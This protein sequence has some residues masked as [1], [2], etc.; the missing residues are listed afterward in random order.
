MRALNE[1]LIERKVEARYVS[2]LLLLWNPMTRQIVMANAGAIPPHDLPRGEILKAA[3]GGRAAG[4]ARCARVRRD[5]PFKRSRGILLVLYSDGITDH[6]NA[7]GTEYGR[8]RLSNAIRMH[9]KTSPAKMIA[10]IFDD[11]DKFS[12][13]PF[14]DQT[15]FA[16]RVR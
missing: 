2:L 12:K 8:G 1:A 5:S 13:T 7:S 9:A 10:A 6:M 4:L 11:M 16:M 3:R 14:D 15:I